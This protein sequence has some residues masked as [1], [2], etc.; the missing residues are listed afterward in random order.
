MILNNSITIN[1]PPQTDNTGKV[2]NP[3][4]IELSVLDVS[5]HDNPINKIVSATIRNIPGHIVLLQEDT[6]ILAG[7]YTQSFIENKLRSELGE[8]PAKKLRSMF[9]KTL[10]E[11]PD[12]PGTILTGMIS[13][14]GIKSTSNCSCRKHAID[15]NIF[16]NDWCE[17]NIGTVLGW[18]K[19]ES[20]KRNLPFVEMV[21][22]LMVQRAIKTSR[23]ALKKKE[24]GNA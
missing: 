1:P 11:D 20:T 5:Y 23:R 3:P 16:G 22:K 9:P 18:L 17:E 21:A 6:Y 24:E 10:E 14:I 19:E 13:S 15:M 12:G 2:I 4:P 7:D 8:D